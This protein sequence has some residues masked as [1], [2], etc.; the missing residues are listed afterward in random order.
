MAGNCLRFCFGCMSCTKITV[1]GQASITKILQ[2]VSWKS[3]ECVKRNCQNLAP[4][5]YRERE[6][7]REHE[8]FIWIWWES[9]NWMDERAIVMLK[10]VYYHKQLRNSISVSSTCDIFLLMPL[11]LFRNEASFF[12]LSQKDVVWPSL[13]LSLYHS[14]SH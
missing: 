6:R 7:E 12:T 13:N 2:A 1:T 14:V 11:L 9:A 3:A 8:S 10:H 4:V 5:R